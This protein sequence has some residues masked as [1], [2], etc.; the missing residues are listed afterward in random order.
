[1]SKTDKVKVKF[2]RS[3]PEYSYAIGET[4]DISREA[5]DRIAKHGPFFEEIKAE[6]AAE[7]TPEPP[8]KEA[9]KAPTTGVKQRKHT[10]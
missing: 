9:E 8:A 4:A 5:F 3:H 7:K 6:K 10:R 2:L 1:M